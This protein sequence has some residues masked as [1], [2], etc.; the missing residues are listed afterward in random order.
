VKSLR[1][2][3]LWNLGWWGMF[4]VWVIEDVPY[5]IVPMVLSL[6]GYTI[7]VLLWED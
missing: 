2:F 3:L 6:A 1:D 4:F 7:I 5:K